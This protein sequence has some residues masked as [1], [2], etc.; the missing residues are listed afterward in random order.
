MNPTLREPDLLEVRPY[1]GRPV[2]AGDVILFH[3]PGRPTPIVHRVERLTP[4]GIHTRGDHCRRRDDWTIGADRIIGRITA[5]QRGGRRRKVANGLSGRLWARM[6]L[7]GLPIGAALNRML[8]GPYRA[9]SEIGGIPRC[10]PPAWRPRKILFQA[11]GRRIWRMMWGRHIIGQYEEGR[12]K[13]RI[14]RPFRLLIDP[15]ELDIES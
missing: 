9:L 10:L 5:A 14:R 13:W 11:G 15:R 2:R 3:A 7:V 8:R 1:H 6:L 4:K 12:G